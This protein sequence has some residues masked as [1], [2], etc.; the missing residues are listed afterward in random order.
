MATPSLVDRLR[1]AQERLDLIIRDAENDRRPHARTE[2]LLD[3]V[4]DLGTVM[5]RIARGGSR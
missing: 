4:H 1:I 5:C 3:D 2:Q